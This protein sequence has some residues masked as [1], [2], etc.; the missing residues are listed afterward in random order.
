MPQI[1]QQL[2]AQVRFREL[3]TAAAQPLHE[4]RERNVTRIQKQMHGSASEHRHECEKH[5]LLS[6]YGVSSDT[7]FDLDHSRKSFAVDFLG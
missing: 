6:N 4:P 7:P 2:L 5:T 3:N 1:A